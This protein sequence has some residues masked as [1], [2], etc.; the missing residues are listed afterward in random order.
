MSFVDRQGW[1]SRKLGLFEVLKD[2]EHASIFKSNSQLQPLLVKWNAPSAQTCPR[3][4]IT[5]SHCSVRRVLIIIIISSES[6]HLLR[7]MDKLQTPNAIPHFLLFS[8]SAFSFHRISSTPWIGAFFFSRRR[9]CVGRGNVFL[10]VWM[11]C[12]NTQ[13]W[14]DYES[15][16]LVKRTFCRIC[17]EGRGLQV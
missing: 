6:L 15:T 2:N 12:D 10:W 14:I 16:S 5:L 3:W 8:L 13:A 7:D 1:I 9:N 11:V 17:T 4:D